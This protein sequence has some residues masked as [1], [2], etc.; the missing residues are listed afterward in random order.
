VGLVLTDAI[1]SVLE[2]HLALLA[3]QD[4]TSW[5]HA[6][7]QRLLL[8]AFIDDLLPFKLIAL[9]SGIDGHE[10]FGVLNVGAETH[11]L[12]DAILRV[13]LGHVLL[14]ALTVGRGRQLEVDHRS[15]SDSVSLDDQRLLLGV[16]VLD[17]G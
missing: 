7:E 12:N 1:R 2:A 5:R 9:V 4:E 15:L 13:D 17:V 14:L 16:Q 6:L 8:V 11:E 3:R 10:A